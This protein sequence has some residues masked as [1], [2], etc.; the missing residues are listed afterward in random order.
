[1]DYFNAVKAFIQVV[2]AGSFVKAA[3][4]MNLPRN[5]VTR[6]IQTLENHLRVK[7][8]NRTTR[9]ISLTNDGTA[10]YERMVRVVDQWLEAES[11]LASAQARPHG[12]LR[13]DMGSTMATML[14]LPALPAFQ[15]RYPELQLDIGVSDR[16]VDLLG[17]RVDCVIRGGTLSDPS[18]IARR[19]GSLKFVTCATP[20]YL[21]THG[22]PLQP[23]D[24]DVGHQMVRYF[25]AGTQQRLPVEFVRGNERITVDAPYFVSVNDSNALLAAAL[26]GIGVLQTLQFMAEPHFQSGALVQLLEDW[27]LEPNPIYIVYSPNRH[28]SARVRVFVEWLVELFEAK[29]LR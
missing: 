18:L 8:L 11:D 14:V 25:F 2:E 23:G 17:D 28:L 20:E 4:T 27:S 10:Y 21:A 13:I 16:P 5:T 29:G 7:L 26:A 1:M 12:R 24:L 15:K 3:Q 9:R 19:L 22:T 6:H